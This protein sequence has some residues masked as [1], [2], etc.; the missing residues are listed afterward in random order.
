MVSSMVLARPQRSPTMPKT[1]P[2]VAHPNMKTAVATPPY[3]VT[4]L[5]GV[6][7]GSSSSSAGPLASTKMRWS[8]V[9]KSH[10]REA[11]IRTHQW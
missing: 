4:S 11:T 10:P 2:P 6:P 7:G 5:A 8:M 3:Q 9:S 1:N